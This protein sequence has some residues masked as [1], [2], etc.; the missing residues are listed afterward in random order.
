M[1]ISDR[2]ILIQIE[3]YPQLSVIIELQLQAER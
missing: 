2:Y 3:I 1:F